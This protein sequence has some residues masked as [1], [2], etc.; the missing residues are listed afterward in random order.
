[1]ATSTPDDM[2]RDMSFLFSPN[3]FNV[4]TS[5]AQALVVLVCNPALL[6]G[7]CKTPEQM[8]LANVLAAFVEMATD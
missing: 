8:R 7:P 6:E 5:R 1:M 3:R 2:P 4:A